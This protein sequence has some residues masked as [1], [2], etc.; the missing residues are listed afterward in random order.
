MTRLKYDFLGR[1][2]TKDAS[3][4]PVM[5]S[6][7]VMYFTLNIAIVV[8]Y[9]IKW[10]Q[11]F[12]LSVAD[13]SALAFVNVAMLAFSIYATSATRASIRDKYMIREHRCYDVEDCCCATF[14]MPC[15]ICQMSRHTTDYTRHEAKCC[16]ETGLEEGAELPNTGSN[17]SRTNYFCGENE[18]GE[19]YWCADERD[20]V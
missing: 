6:I 10:S 8:A 3:T 7:I 1:P 14:C 11:G 16:T 20:L 13:I 19:Q 17:V 15:T 12:E 2:R 18:G 5:S 9:N 4:F